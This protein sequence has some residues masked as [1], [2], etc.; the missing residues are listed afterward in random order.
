MSPDE[1][2]RNP[3]RARV[4]D[5]LGAWVLLAALIAAVTLAAVVAAVAP[6]I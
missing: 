4:E 1:T 2:E 6:P 3:S 5:V